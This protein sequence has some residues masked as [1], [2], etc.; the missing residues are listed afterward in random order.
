[1]VPDI[2]NVSYIVHILSIRVQG[3]FT[4]SSGYRIQILYWVNIL[5]MEQTVDI[6]QGKHI[7]TWKYAQ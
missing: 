2:Y 7:V 3:T 5:H 4:V 6:S 1:M